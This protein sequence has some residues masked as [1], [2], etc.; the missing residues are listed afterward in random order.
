MLNRI[1]SF[2]GIGGG[3]IEA[4]SQ[5][6]VIAPPKV[7]PGSQGYP[8]YIKT[9]R[10]QN[11]VLP[12]TD[13]RLAT[14][15]I[16]SAVRSKS[17]T[18]GVIRELVA[19]SPDLS[20]AV[21]SYIRTAITST[22]VAVAK[23]PDGTFNP[24]A[25]ALTQQLLTRFDVLTDYSDGFSGISS[26]LSNSESL[27][28]EVLTYG[29]MA[30]ELVLGKDRLPR[31]IQ[32]I[33]VT[34]VKFKPDPK[35]PKILM[36]VQ[37]IGG[38]EIDLDFP[39]FFYVALDQD[40]LEPYASSPLESA[41]Q[42]VLFNQGF[43]NDIQRVIKRALHPRLSVTIDQEKFAANLSAEQKQDD[44]KRAEALNNLLT[45]IDS[46]INGLNP[47]DA[48]ILVDTLVAD[49]LNNGNASLSS[50]YEVLSKMTDSKMATGA[51]TLP[52]I[53]GHGAGSSNI[54]STETM[55]FMKNAY[56]AV[57][58]K[59]NEFY[60]RVLTLAVR[61]FG[62]DVYVEFKYDTIDLRPDTELESFRQTK[63]AR[64]L[65]QLSFGFITDE[66]AS[67]Q[68][69]GKLP[70]KGFKPLSGTQFTVTKPKQN[71]S[72]PGENPP[73]NDG[74]AA[75]KATKSDQPAQGRGGNKKVE[76]ENGEH[77]VAAPLPPQTIEFHAHVEAT[78]PRQ[79]ATVMKMRRDDEGNL[80]VERLDTEDKEVANG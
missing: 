27:A 80:V 49:Y 7:K 66:E 71:G 53:L 67:L 74:S 77:E 60:S 46:T 57:Q 29:A 56:G 23:N 28:K 34:S 50:E 9:T 79:T 13:R 40:L 69:T 22:Y 43:M 8:S 54:A 62:Y 38:E 37:V 4:G 44:E 36:P 52:A 55:L 51:K 42:P 64:V 25:T 39:T 41:I 58:G 75:N 2:F 21:F 70:P 18:Q 65:E 6:P 33:S 45:T 24:D 12:A 47:E 11:T 19:A 73:T 30:G 15:E 17:G 20:A 72:M 26:M 76:G 1:K 31:R 32:P 68:L 3:T 63:Q 14:T 16:T 48:L 78:K 59:L 5:L 61:L 10:T 35:D